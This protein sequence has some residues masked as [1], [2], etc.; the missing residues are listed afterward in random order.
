MMMIMK[1]IK[2]PNKNRRKLRFRMMIYILNQMLKI[3]NRILK[4]IKNLVTLMLKMTLV[5]VV[6]QLI[7]LLLYKHLIISNYLLM[8]S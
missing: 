2:N 4:N 5:H 7:M 6:N 8:E 3:L 1:E